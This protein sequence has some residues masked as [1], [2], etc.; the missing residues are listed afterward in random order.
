[1]PALP[2][3]AGKK[4]AA[5]PFI[6]SRVQSLPKPQPIVPPGHDAV[7]KITTGL[8]AVSLG[9]PASAST[10]G[11]GSAKPKNIVLGHA[12]KRF[13]LDDVESLP[14]QLKETPSFR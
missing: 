9:R 4:H 7:V 6:A 10:V 3:K 13:V 12:D 8:A 14:K 11:G 1:L 5:V 2:S